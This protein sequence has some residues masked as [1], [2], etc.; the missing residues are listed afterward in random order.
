MNRPTHRGINPWPGFTLIELLVVIAII[1]IL[2]ALLLPALSSA[3]ARAQ[4]IRCL[5]NAKQLDL[6]WQLYAEDFGGR[7]VPNHGG[8]GGTNDWCDGWFTQPPGTDNTN[9]MLLQNGLLWHYST[10]T[11]IYKCPG[12]PSINVRSYALNGFMN[13][14]SVDGAGVVFLTSASIPRPTDL[15]VFLDEDWQTLNDGFFRVDVGP[16]YSPYDTPA[17]YHNHGGRLAFADGHAEGRRWIYTP[18]DVVWLQQHA[19]IKK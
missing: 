6:A 5:N 1:A 17:D 16:N 19:T 8:P 18:A 11:A 7:L 15:Y 12:D 10:S 4:G 14:I 2:A 9:L 13:G 3:K